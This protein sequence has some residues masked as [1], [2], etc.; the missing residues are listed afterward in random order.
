MATRKPTPKKEPLVIRAHSL[1]RDTDRFLQQLRHEASDALGWTVSSSAIV[2]A[3]LQVASQQ[4]SSW[5]ATAL[6]PVIDREIAE[7][8]VW[9]RKKK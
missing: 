7:G 5:I 3:L 2:R 1:T 9:G 8:F 6:F 4:P